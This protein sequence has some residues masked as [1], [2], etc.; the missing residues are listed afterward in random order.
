M[1]VDDNRSSDGPVDLCQTCVLK[2]RVR[3]GP[4]IHEFRALLSSNLRC[5]CASE[6]GCSTVLDS[7]VALAWQGSYQRLTERLAS[8]IS[9]EKN[10]WEKLGD[11]WEFDSAACSCCEPSRL[12][13]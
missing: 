4:V 1:S 3:R 2:N 12:H 9:E 13:S 6:R 10:D 8:S 5:K 7:E 11:R